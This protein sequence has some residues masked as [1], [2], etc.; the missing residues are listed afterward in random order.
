MRHDQ[1]EDLRMCN[2][3]CLHEFQARDSVSHLRYVYGAYQKYE[4]RQQLKNQK[5]ISKE[6]LDALDNMTPNGLHD[7]RL[8]EFNQCRD[9]CVQ[10]SCTGLNL[11]RAM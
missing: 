7:P 8:D 3:I 2:E 9:K 6:T 5:T 4:E 1:H 10:S 11:A